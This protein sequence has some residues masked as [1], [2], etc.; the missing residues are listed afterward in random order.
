[1]ERFSK[2]FHAHSGSL[3]I[4]PSSTPCGDRRAR[5]GR[6]ECSVLPSDPFPPP[7]RVARDCRAPSSSCQWTSRRC[8]RSPTRSVL[9][10]LPLPAFLAPHTP[11]V[12]IVIIERT[13]FCV[14]FSGFRGGVGL[15]RTRGALARGRAQASRV[16]QPAAPG[17]SARPIG[18][19]GCPL[20]SRAPERGRLRGLTAARATRSRCGRSDGPLWRAR[21]CSEPSQSLSSRSLSSCTRRRPRAAACA[22]WC[23]EGREWLQGTF[24]GSR[25]GRPRA[26]GRRVSERRSECP[27]PLRARPPRLTPGILVRGEGRGVSD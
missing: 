26:R 16:L 3:F 24:S 8:T 9:V 12:L 21:C 6:L 10:P 1:L 13:L 20:R 18:S 14:S 17:A 2:G 23:D 19:R 22:R 15:P 27:A 11:K 7:P 4:P 5:R 25:R